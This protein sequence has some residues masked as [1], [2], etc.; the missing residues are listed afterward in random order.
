MRFVSLHILLLFFLGGWS[1]PRNDFFG[2]VSF[3]RAKT[4]LVKDGLQIMEYNA[5]LVGMQKFNVRF[6]YTEVVSGSGKVYVSGRICFGEGAPNDCVGITGVEIFTAKRTRKNRLKRIRK[7]TLS[8][9]DKDS[10]EKVGFF[11]FE[12]KFK[13]G[14]RLFFFSKNFLLE[15]YMI[16]LSK[17]KS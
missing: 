1:Q 8:S 5:P 16:S 12:K 15:E 11:R 2:K 9:Y 10:F 4:F 14:E 3:T 6:L 17:I 7:L 13:R